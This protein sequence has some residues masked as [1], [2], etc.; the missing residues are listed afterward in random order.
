MAWIASEN[1]HGLRI[2]PVKRSFLFGLCFVWL[3]SILD[4]VFTCRHLEYGAVEL[5]PLFAALF[6]SGRFTEAF[7]FKLLLTSGSL[8]VLSFF[9]FKKSAQ[10]A[11]TVIACG[12][13]LLLLYHL[14]GFFT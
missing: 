9:S 8:A 2:W 14:T 11:L 3:A 13:G 6:N 5:N 1:L 12:Y 10:K 7:F 4:F